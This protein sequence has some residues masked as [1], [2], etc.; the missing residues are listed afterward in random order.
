MSRWAS[1]TD[2]GG[3]SSF[4][5]E[6]VDVSR[7]PT[8]RRW[9]CGS[10]SPRPWR[11]R[12]DAT[13]ASL[14]VDGATLS[15]AFDAGVLVYRAVADA[16]VETVTV[17][18]S[19][20]GGGAAVAYGPAEDADTALA[21]YQV[22]VPEGE[23]LVE[24]TVTAADGT[25]RRYRVVVARAKDGVNTAPENTA[26]TGLPAI[27]GT[28]EVGEALTVSADDIA[29]GDGLDKAA[30]AWQWL[31]D[32]GTVETAIA[33]ATGESY[34]LTPA[35]VGKTLKVRVTFTDDKDTVET[36]VSVATEAVAA[37]VPSAPVDLAVATG[38]GRERELTVSWTAPG[39]N[40]G[41]EVTGYRVQ[42]KSGTEAWDG[43]QT[44]TRQAVL[45][46][47][48]ATG[49]TIAEL[50]NG[51]AY[52]VRV[53]A[54]N[55]AGDGAAAEAGAT[56]Q[57]R[58]APVLTGAAVDGAVLTL[59]FSEAL[60]QDSAPA[61]GSFAVTVADTARTVDGVAVSG[62]A[63]ELTLASG[64]VSGETV[65]VGY[66]VPA[67]AG[68]NRLRDAAGNAAAGFTGEA[69]SNETEASN[70]APAG[71]P[72]ISGT[73]EVGEELTASADDIADADGLENVTFVYQ[74]LAN[75]GTDD[76]EIAGATGPTHEVAPAEAGKT[77][78]VRVTFTDDKGHEETLVSAATD[79]VV[80]R[81]PVAATLSVGDGAAEAGR[82]RL[83]VAFGDAVTGLDLA[84]LAA[85][86]VGG[87][88]A[89]VSDL[90][91]AETGRVWTAWVAAAQAGRYTVR[92]AAG[93]AE[94]GARRSLAAV[95]A[96]DV[97]AAGNAVAVS[98]PVVT[99]VALATASDG[100]WADGD[101]VRVMLAFSEPVTVAADG[102]TPTVGIGLDGT[103]RRAAY[104]SGSGTGTLAVFSYTVTADDG[105]CRRRR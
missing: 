104:A 4:S 25:V 52:A 71:L 3:D 41:S 23:A 103:A 100:T 99:A 1:R 93:A 12:A 53:L 21:D 5:L 79:A 84:D 89:A 69:A 60:N 14:T 43:S 35:D 15:P 73:A 75:D 13:L 90:A 49:H 48:A 58:V 6:N 82:F 28:A 32:D 51:T 37:T 63:A 24:V 47:P 22:A 29:D 11:S 83:R 26:P 105:R 59:T 65:T 62:S 70:T 61:A 80:D 8:A 18:A 98:G 68:A 88:A 42:W 102:G 50:A 45:S 72:A 46:D 66:A 77:L 55:A 31:A 92:L 86:R 2:S 36:L 95:L 9:R 101:T 87:D 96:V 38:E 56:V 30:F 81:R 97:D 40:G 57:D 64:V 76:S 67:D 74:W 39:S 7:G 17:T 85:A 94:S 19:A 54:V 44:S 16:G 33:D 20:N 34:K 78:K 27:S 10:R 91:E